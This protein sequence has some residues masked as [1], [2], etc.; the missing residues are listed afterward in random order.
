[1]AL[2]RTFG[3]AEAA[4]V[5]AEV[6]VAIRVAV[7]GI[8]AEAS[9][10]AGC[11]GVTAVVLRAVGG[12]LDEV[13]GAVVLAVAEAVL[14]CDLNDGAGAVGGWRRRGDCDVTWLAGAAGERNNCREG[15]GSSGG[16]AGEWHAERSFASLG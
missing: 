12:A 13:A 7:D 11:G 1:M 15:E 9:V 4:V 8:G 16:S 3:A 10:V 2:V 6:G 14:L 5:A